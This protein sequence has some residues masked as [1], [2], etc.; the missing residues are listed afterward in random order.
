MQKSLIYSLLSPKYFLAFLLLPHSRPAID[1]KEIGLKELFFPELPLLHS[2]RLLLLC[3]SQ[4][5][6][7]VLRLELLCLSGRIA[8]LIEQKWVIRREAFNWLF[9]QNL[10]S[11]STGLQVWN[12]KDPIWLQECWMKTS[13]WQ[14]WG[15]MWEPVESRLQQRLRWWRKESQ[16][17]VFWE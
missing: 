10:W 8:R 5:L 17:A 9:F 12:R 14:Q 4:L 1:P 13:K 15:H 16:L 11:E 6:Y 7:Q 3:I 2:A